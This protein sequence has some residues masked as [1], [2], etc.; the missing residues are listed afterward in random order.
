[1]ENIDMYDE[2]DVEIDETKP[3]T[4]TSIPSENTVVTG[5]IGRGACF[6]H[7]L[8]YCMSPREYR[9]MSQKERIKFVIEFRKLLAKSITYEEW[10]EIPG[11][12]LGIQSRIQKIIASFYKKIQDVSIH[13]V[14]YKTHEEFLKTDPYSRMFNI[15][16]FDLEE[17]KE[18]IILNFG[19]TENL[20]NRIMDT[21]TASSYKNF[22][23]EIADEGS[24][25]S[26]TTFRIIGKKFETFVIFI[27]KDTG[28][29]YQNVKIEKHELESY[30]F[31]VLLRYDGG[32]FESLGIVDHTNTIIRLFEIDDSRIKPLLEEH[33]SK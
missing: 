30:K 33:L 23:D 19:G 4:I 12:E 25:I 31:A 6:I 17:Y 26:D 5:V 20:V 3:F 2:I 29:V 32:H 14:K 7:A 27:N 10:L 15:K 24:Y 13:L 8:L 1:M 9:A 11:I 18:K 21:A 16:N 22:Q 28:N